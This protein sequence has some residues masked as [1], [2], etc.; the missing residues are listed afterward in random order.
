MWGR[1]EML[2]NP[3]AKRMYLLW[4]W[5]KMKSFVSTEVML[6]VSDHQSMLWI[7]EWTGASYILLVFLVQR[8]S[9]KCSSPLDVWSWCSP[10]VVEQTGTALGPS[11]QKVTEQS[12]DFK[13]F[14]STNPSQWNYLL[15]CYLS[16]YLFKIQASK[17]SSSLSPTLIIHNF[18]DRIESKAEKAIAW[19]F[20]TCLPWIYVRWGNP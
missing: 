6:R 18:S 20:V 4:A 7:F 2:R 16:F 17:E 9:A 15:V 5:D 1:N 11:S 3:E 13:V 8:K 10:V 19:K 14:I 12:I